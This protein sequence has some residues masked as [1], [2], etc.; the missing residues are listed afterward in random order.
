MKTEFLGKILIPIGDI[1]LKKLLLCLSLNEH[2]RI[3]SL[4]KLCEWFFISHRHDHSFTFT[5]YLHIHEK[6]FTL[7][8][9]PHSLKPF[10]G[11][12]FH[13]INSGFFFAYLINIFGTNSVPVASAGNT[14][15]IW[16]NNF[17]KTWDF[18]CLHCVISPRMTYM[19]VLTNKCINY[20]LNTNFLLF[21]VKI[22]LC[23]LGNF[24]QCFFRSYL[25]F[26]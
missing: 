16:H 26:Q 24:L 8:R 14:V 17:S 1:F 4:E 10:A 3:H 12:S 11:T 21:L 6:S 13:N 25:R 22:F 20:S 23:S 7:H 9:H 5:H 2:E 15:L 19:G 18:F